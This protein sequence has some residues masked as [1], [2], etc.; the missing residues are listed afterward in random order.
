MKIVFFTESY[1]P[2]LS[3]VTVAVETLAKI[4][5]GQGHRVWIFAPDYPQKKRS[6]GKIYR[7]P[8]IATKKYPG[9]RVACPLGSGIFKKI[10]KISPQIIHSHSPYTLGIIARHCARKLKIP[11]VYSFHTIF[12]DYL[13]YFPIFPKM[14]S[15]LILNQYF[16]WFLKNTPT[17][18][19]TAYT[20]ELTISL[21]ASPVEIIPTGVD[22]S[23]V[24][25]GAG[26]NL[27]EKLRLWQNPRILLYVGRLSKEKNLPFLLEV[28]SRLKQLRPDVHLVLIGSG[29]EENNLKKLAHNLKINDFVTFIR[30]VPHQ[31]IFSYYR[32]ADIFACPSKSETQGIV[33]I[34]AMAVGLPVVA[35]E[36]KGV[37][38]IIKS[39]FGFLVEEKVETFSAKV[40]EL[41]ESEILL[42]DMSRKAKKASL[43]NYSS[44]VMARKTEK[45][46]QKI[47]ANFSQ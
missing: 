14:I 16:K 11:F 12:S 10:K 20:R 9:F 18:V 22:F 3:G 28:M 29:P 26:V 24:Y 5:T 36:A 15:S 46:Y 41:L 23:E 4:L 35:I 21:G 30:Q 25:K 19:P 6:L 8:S 27:K 44:Q 42:K 1:K 45:F 13:H 34:E 43:E 2:Y 17:I 37:S 32:D 38:D 47:L 40:L 31:E 33:L 39:E 7:L